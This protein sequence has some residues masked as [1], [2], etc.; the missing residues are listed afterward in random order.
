[1]EIY[2][3][4]S[5]N[6]FE[7]YICDIVSSLWLASQVLGNSVLPSFSHNVAH[8]YLDSVSV[9]FLAHLSRR[10]LVKLIVYGGIRRPSVVVVRGREHF[11][12]TSP[13]KP[14]SRFFS[15]FT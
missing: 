4:W 1:M 11:Q 12:T 6:N 15:Y 5:L 14:L 2:I 8:M 13:L 3:G 7:E 10:L 9:V